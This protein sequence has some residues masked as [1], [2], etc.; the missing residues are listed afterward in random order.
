MQHATSEQPPDPLGVVLVR[1]DDAPVGERNANPSR[2]NSQS[3]GIRRD[4]LVGLAICTP[5]FVASIDG[6]QSG[7]Y[8]I[9]RRDTRGGTTLT[10]TPAHLVQY[11]ANNQAALMWLSGQQVYEGRKVFSK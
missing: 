6:Y 2:P 4:S 7:R 5:D 10:L 8:H 1:R 9:H 3:Q 11:L